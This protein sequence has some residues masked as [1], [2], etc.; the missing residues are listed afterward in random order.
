[1]RWS[2][3]LCAVTGRRL[4]EASGA[5]RRGEEAADGPGAG[6]GL[7]PR[8][9]LYLQPLTRARAG[10]GRS[11]RAAARAASGRTGRTSLSPWD[12]HK[13]SPL[14]ISAS[15]SD[16]VA[17]G[18][19]GPGERTVSITTAAGRTRLCAEEASAASPQ[20]N[21]KC[22]PGSAAGP[23]WRPEG[24]HLL[25]TGAA[26]MSNPTSLGPFCLKGASAQQSPPRG[27][28]YRKPRM[29]NTSS[30]SRSQPASL[31]SSTVA[32]AQAVQRSPRCGCVRPQPERSVPLLSWGSSGAAPAESFHHTTPR[33][34]VANSSSREGAGKIRGSQ[35]GRH[36]VEG[37][38]HHSAPA[39]GCPISDCE[40]LAVWILS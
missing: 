24:P 9:R 31:A 8:D 39:A 2:R 30:P 28:G 10:R 11:G 35:P 16:T 27:R 6:G 32:E 3:S 33:A 18:R 26:G 22:Q 17:E 25:L 14:L 40:K 38:S 21:P 19:P 23:P 15:G 37:K 12:G 34:K 4:A 1:M 36:G 5:R 20:Q 29:G 7:L 13:L